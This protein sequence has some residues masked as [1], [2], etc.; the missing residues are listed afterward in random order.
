M[1]DRKRAVARRMDRRD[2]VD[3]EGILLLLLWRLQEDECCILVLLESAIIGC[4]LELL[5]IAWALGFVFAEK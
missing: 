2:V 4:G 1:G 5:F 3:N